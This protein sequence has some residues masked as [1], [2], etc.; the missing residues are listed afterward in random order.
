MEQI[1]RY[2]TESY[3]ELI[4][5]VTWP[6]LPNLLGSTKV[7]L[8]GSTIIAI[9]VLVMDAISKQITDILYNL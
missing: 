3:N 2:L 6:T 5:K 1:K 8:V 7:V 9:V 4:N